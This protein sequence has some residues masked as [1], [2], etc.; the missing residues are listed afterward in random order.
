M[1][2]PTH[3]D[4]SLVA[5]TAAPARAN[6]QSDRG[7][8]WRP[9]SGDKENFIRVGALDLS[10]WGKTAHVNVAGVGR[11]RAGYESGLS[12]DRRS[13]RDFPCRSCRGCRRLRRG[14]RG[15]ILRGRGL[16]R[17]S[18]CRSRRR[19][20]ELGLRR[21]G[22]LVAEPIRARALGKRC[23]RCHFDKLQARSRVRWRTRSRAKIS[24]R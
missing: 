9:C 23:S 2:A 1:N 21:L 18:W 11:V 22:P 7:Q 6:R 10:S 12:G 17:R 24:W 3:A 8:K 5:A 20:G 15:G 4:S 16:G 19:I 13:V 14:T